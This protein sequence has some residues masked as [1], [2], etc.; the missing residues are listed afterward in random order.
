MPRLF[1]ASYFARPKGVRARGSRILSALCLA[2]AG[3][4]LVDEDLSR[5]ATSSDIDYEMRLVTNLTAELETQVSAQVELTAVASAL[6]Q[7]LSSVFTDLAHDVDL[8]FY[9]VQGDSARLHHEAHIMDASE[10][11][12]TLFIPRR[13][14][15]H[16][17]V[18][19]LEQC[20]Q[21]QLVNDE[22]CHSAKLLRTAQ[23]NKVSSLEAGV[24]AARLPMEMKEGVDE[25]FDVKLGMVNCAGALALDTLGSGLG[26]IKVCMS[27]FA[28]GLNL[29]DSSYIF[30]AT[31]EVLADEVKVE[32][33]RFACFCAV[34]FP[35]KDVGT[36]VVIDT[37][38]PFV[39]PEAAE[40]LW[41]CTVYVSTK[42]GSV[43]KT[44][45]GVKQ[46]LRPGQFKL[47]RAKVEP[48]GSVMPTEQYV[49]VS[50]T[51]DW[52][53]QPGWDIDI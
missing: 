22:R 14:Y 30:Q 45:L 47:I 31:P 4:T 39:S 48:D 49:G 32:D 15:M 36:K 2:I 35:S 17:A 41:N 52:N 16:L 50:V 43:T 9:D 24:F 10:Q 25:H 26:G 53:E 42:D 38:D 46:P 8:S 3:C 19:N 51:L 7:H 1:C 5:C 12:F 28:N 6:Q 29:A 21:L 13:E 33:G 18:A 11:S 34:T 23:D 27:G 20:G 40:A 44:D 37:E